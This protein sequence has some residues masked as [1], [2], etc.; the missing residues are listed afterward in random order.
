MRLLRV[1]AFAAVVASTDEVYDFTAASADGFFDASAP[2]AAVVDGATVLSATTP[3]ATACGA[4]F[5]AFGAG[6]FSLYFS[7]AMDPGTPSLDHDV[8]LAAGESDGEVR[9]FAFLPFGRVV[10]ATYALAA[11]VYDAA[12]VAATATSDAVALALSDIGSAAVAPAFFRAAPDAR[13][14]RPTR[15]ARA[16]ASSGPTPSPRRRRARSPR[17]RRRPTRSASW[18]ACWR[19]SRRGGDDYHPEAEDG[20]GDCASNNVAL[21][22]A[23]ASVAAVSSNYGGGSSSSSY[24]ADK[25]IGGSD[26]SQWSSDGDGDGASITI[27][28]PSATDVVGV[29]FYSRSMTNSAVI[30]TYE[31]RSADGEVL[32]TCALPDADALYACDVAADGAESL[33][34]AAV[35][36]TGGNTGARTVEVYGCASTGGAARPSADAE[37]GRGRDAG[38]DEGRRGRRRGTR[39]LFRSRGDARS[40][41]RRLLGDE[42]ADD[43]DWFFKKKKRDCAWVSKNPAARCNEDAEAACAEACCSCDEDDASWFAKKATR[44]CAWVAK[45]KTKSRCK[46]KGRDGDG[47]KKKAKVACPVACCGW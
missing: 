45:K 1:L 37:R 27:A 5:R 22:S 33:T 30:Q 17:S 47:K 9:F 20:S 13:P 39:A 4:A 29:G 7:E 43:A 34:F 23:G 24:G 46:K 6:A 26:S 28:L 25:A 19:V 35:S 44:D 38:A 32:A 42:C 16:T 3:L 8:A 2:S 36:T 31:V 10:S 18:V 15:P 11:A 21:A 41:L 14:A 40:D 12:D